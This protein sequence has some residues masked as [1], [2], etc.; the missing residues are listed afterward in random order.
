VESLPLS[1]LARRE[2]LR[3]QHMQQGQDARSRKASSNVAQSESVTVGEKDRWNHCIANTG[4]THEDEYRAPP[5]IV[6]ALDLEVHP[7]DR[8]GSAEKHA[9]PPALKREVPTEI[10]LGRRTGDEP[11]KEPHAE[12]GSDARHLTEEV[13]DEEDDGS[14]SVPGC[15]P[16]Q[17]DRGGQRQCKRKACHCHDQQGDVCRNAH[18]TS[19]ESGGCP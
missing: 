14:G 17:V 7:E 3:V 4:V 2:G 12:A 1:K 15:L 6:V 11:R 9:R 5:D 8:L 10:P 16:S 13:P 18:H 19:V